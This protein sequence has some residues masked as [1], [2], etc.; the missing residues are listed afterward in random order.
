MASPVAIKQA[1]RAELVRENASIMAAV[2]AAGEFTTPQRDRLN[3]IESALPEIDAD[4]ELLARA[5]ERIITSPKVE[6]GMDPAALGFTQL[7]RPLG[8]MADQVLGHEAFGAWQKQVSRTGRQES[9]AVVLNGSILRR[10]SATIITGGS[11]TSG[12]AFIV[13]DRTS[14]YDD[15]FMPSLR[16][17]DL[18]TI[19]GTESDTVEFVRV[20]AVT[21]AA[22]G[23]AEADSSSSDDSTGLKPESAIAFEVVQPGVKTIAHWVPVTNNALADARQL[24]TIIDGFLRYGVLSKVEAQMLGG[25][26]ADQLPGLATTANVQSQSWDTDYLTTTRRALGKVEYGGAAD[27]AENEATAFVLNPLDWVE[28]DLEMT[29]AGNGTNNRQAGTRTV[30]TLHGLPVVKSKS[31]A[32]GTGWV[33]D[34]RQAVLWDREQTIIRVGQPNNFF[35]KNMNAV[36]AEARAAW[37]VVRPSAFCEIDLGGS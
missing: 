32:I 27:E 12:G 8:S 17:R 33:A 11:A 13:P 36:L 37:G 15:M 25:S 7:H 30:P 2:E 34:W 35:L 26:G 5:R 4:I 18:V 23:V 24:R 28:I 3:A 20:T 10:P 1:E 21:N 19:G 22:T 29:L 6:S 31:V 16:L 14:I 9:P